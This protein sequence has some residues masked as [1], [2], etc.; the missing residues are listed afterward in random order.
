MTK[1][2]TLVV[3]TLLSVW[4]PA[5]RALATRNQSRTRWSP[6]AH[7]GRPWSS[8]FVKAQVKKS[9][10]KENGIQTLASC[11]ADVMHARLSSHLI[12]GIRVIIMFV[13]N[14]RKSTQFLQ[15]AKFKAAPSR[16]RATLLNT[17]IPRCLTSRFSKPECKLQIYSS[18]SNKLSHK[19]ELKTRL[20]TRRRPLRT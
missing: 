7:R 10:S 4:G 2:R 1:A 14:H 12:L 18:L 5:P 13:S 8:D 6:W 15:R 19:L 3:L 17:A 20:R 11:I 16:L 9:T